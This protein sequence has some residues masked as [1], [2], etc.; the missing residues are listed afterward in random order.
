VLDRH[1]E[2]AF[3][4]MSDM[5]WHPRFGELE[6]EREVVLEE[7]AM[8]EDD[9][10]DR[11]F[12]VLGKAV[13]DSHPLGRPVIGTAEVIGVATR[14]QLAAFHAERY[15]PR[16]V[17]IAAAGSV[18][19]DALV[20]MARAVEPERGPGRAPGSPGAAIAPPDFKRRV[21]FL[22]KD[23]E[24]YHVCIGGAGI[25]RDDERRFALRVLEGVLG[26]TSSSRLFQEVRE[27]RGL[28]YSVFCFSNLYAETGEVGLYL[29]TRSE[30]LN[31]AIAVVA[32]ELVRCVEAPASDEELT[33]SREN[34]KGRVVLALESTG[35]RMSRLGTSVM[36]ELPILSV[37]ELIERI[38]SV[39]INELRE[40]AE[41]F[42]AERL[43]VAGVGSDE[44]AFRAAIAPLSAVV[45]GGADSDPD[46]REQTPVERVAQ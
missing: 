21:R 8:Y 12:D 37:D 28:A 13:F 29:G 14:E 11:V 20:E 17:V 35:A 16:S 1:L 25:A 4:V 45:P 9:P 44:E 3:E 32:R 24:Q 36:N 33:R 19:H 2:R 41:L 7:I 40:L 6:A 23:T 34:L 15:Q 10:Q 18:D 38:D 46:T 31:E 39:G 30:N 22:Q 27:R 42:T 5:V 26:G 43:S